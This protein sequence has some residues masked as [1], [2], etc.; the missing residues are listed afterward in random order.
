VELA[1]DLQRYRESRS[2]SAIAPTRIER[3]INWSR[4][5]PRLAAV[6]ST[7][8]GVVMLGALV[9]AFE[10]SVENA[11]VAMAYG[12]IDEIEASMATTRSNIAATRERLP[13]LPAGTQRLELEARLHDLEAELEVAEDNRKS[14]ALAITGFTILSPDQRAIDIV[15]E[16]VL[17]EIQT[18]VERGDW[19]RARA[20]IEMTLRNSE[21]RNVFGLSDNELEALRAQLH[22][23]ERQIDNAERAF[24]GE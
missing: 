12:L 13:T 19:R 8:V 7:L 4:R 1:D 18:L 22:T 10:A 23:A 2:V 16:T 6:T 5:R 17:S 15:R 9:A 11:R 20:R 21:A 3:L 14:L 24:R